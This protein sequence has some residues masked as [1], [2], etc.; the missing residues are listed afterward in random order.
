MDVLPMMTGNTTEVVLDG[1]IGFT[2]PAPGSGGR[3]P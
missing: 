3:S 1:T 2:N